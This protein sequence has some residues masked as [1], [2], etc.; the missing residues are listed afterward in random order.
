M[1]KNQKININ[2]APLGGFKGQKTRIALVST[3]PPCSSS[4]QASIAD[5]IPL[6]HAYYIVG[7][8]DG[9]G[10]FNV[11]FRKRNDYLIGWKLTPVFNVS[12]KEKLPLTYLKKHLSCGTIRYRKDGVWVYEV[13]NKNA[14]KNI[15]IPFFEK[16][17]FISAWK[18]KSFQSF[19]KILDFQEKYQ[20]LFFKQELQ[21]IL[22]LRNFGHSNL[23]KRTYSDQDILDRY[24][25]FWN[26]NSEK[27]MAKR[28]KAQDA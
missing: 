9:E 18:K 1:K 12:Q 23:A 3:T 5:T 27:I 24:D 7:F 11:S 16:Y 22:K 28:N 2:Q 26:L 14:L 6:K 20:G 25:S 4:R 19:K 15:I 13:T 8:T 10:S 17:S 21:D